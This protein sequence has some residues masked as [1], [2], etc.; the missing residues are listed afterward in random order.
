MINVVLKGATLL[1][2][3][4]MTEAKISTCYYAGSAIHYDKH[5]IAWYH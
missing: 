4:F 2:I 1:A 3:D 5:I